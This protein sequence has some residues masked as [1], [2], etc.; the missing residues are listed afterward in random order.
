[1]RM[2]SALALRFS[3]CSLDSRMTGARRSW[4]SSYQALEA[5]SCRHS[6][7]D[8][9]NRST[10]EF[11]RPL[12]SDEVRYAAPDVSVG[13]TITRLNH[14]RSSPSVTWSAAVAFLTARS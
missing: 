2:R 12:V 6:T 13:E 8:F 14:R 5:V 4:D 9:V 10:V 3:H 7:L 11:G 1:C